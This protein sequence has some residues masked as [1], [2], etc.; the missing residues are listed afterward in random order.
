MKMT[1]GTTTD[2][3]PLQQEQIYTTRTNLYNK[4]KFIQQEQIYE[5]IYEQKN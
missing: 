1:R 5:Q 3:V 4:N 2:T